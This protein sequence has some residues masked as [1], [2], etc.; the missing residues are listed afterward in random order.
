[1]SVSVETPLPLPLKETR[2]PQLSEKTTRAYM[3]LAPE[4]GYDSRYWVEYDK[5]AK[6]HD[7][8]LV[9]TL[10]SRLDNLIIFA[11]LFSAV[12]TAFIILSLGLLGATPSDNTN[13]LLRLFLSQT[14]RDSSI[15]EA[16]SPPWEPAA[17]GVRTSYLFA[18]SLSCSLLTAAGALVGK[19]WLAYYERTSQTG[20]QNDWAIA[21]QRKS[22]AIEAYH[23]RS[24]L[25]ALSILIQI[26]VL[27]FMIGLIVYIDDLHRGVASVVLAAVVFGSAVYL[28][29]VVV[30]VWDP[31]CPF[32]TPTS[33]ILR[34]L[35]R[36]LLAFCLIFVKSI[37]R[38]AHSVVTR[39]VGNARSGNAP[40][41]GDLEAGAAEKDTGR[42]IFAISQIANI[43]KRGPRTSVAQSDKT[44]TSVS[45][46]ST[47]VDVS[48]MAQSYAKSV[49]WMLETTTNKVA[50]LEAARNI[51]T[52]HDVL[53]TRAIFD[54]RVA[55]V[56]IRYP[57]KTRLM[58]AKLWPQKPAQGSDTSSHHSITS[59]TFRLTGR[60]SAMLKSPAYIRLVTLYRE[61]LNR[62]LLTQNQREAPGVAIEAAVVYG[63][64]ICHALI[65]SP[66]ASDGF[67]KLTKE[68]QDFSNLSWISRIDG[69][70]R[71]ILMCTMNHP[72]FWLYLEDMEESWSTVDAS[73]LPVYIASLTITSLSESALNRER[74]LTRLAYRALSISESIP[75]PRLIGLAARSLSTL[76][77]EGHS[78]IRTLM[79]GL[80]DAYSSDDN[81]ID[82]VLAALHTYSSGPEVTPAY[83]TTY[84][85]LAT[86]FRKFVETLH[87]TL[88]DDFFPRAQRLQ[89]ERHRAAL[90]EHATDVLGAFEAILKDLAE[91][92]GGANHPPET[93]T[94]GT[95]LLTVLPENNHKRLSRGDPQTATLLQ[96][97]I[98]LTLQQGI[99]D[100][101]WGVYNLQPSSA[102]LWE[103]STVVE[104]D[105][106]TLGVVLDLMRRTNEDRTGY[107]DLFQKFPSVASIITKALTS[108]H[109]SVRENSIRLMREKAQSWFHG[110][111]KDVDYQFSQAE[112][113]KSLALHVQLGNTT[114]GRVLSIIRVFE[115]ETMWRIKFLDA[116][117]KVALSVH[118]APPF[119]DS[120][121][122][123]QLALDVW[124]ELT[125]TGAS[126]EMQPVEV[127]ARY[128]D[129]LSEEMVLVITNHIQQLMENFRRADRWVQSQI[130]NVGVSQSLQEYTEAT[131][132]SPRLA[133]N[134]AKRILIRTFQEWKSMVEPRPGVPESRSSL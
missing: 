9:M 6:N 85:A 117:Y 84:A 52:L 45:D 7:Q 34:H 89:R 54:K 109:A 103:T 106:D 59:A 14:L 92:V 131:R 65:S 77:Y 118:R 55:P 114:H 17:V 56:L 21:R 27:L 19:Q 112:F 24:I 20:T 44:D 53:A 94:R 122:I 36:Y 78:D 123:T 43:F 90:R 23:F 102:I 82:H 128:N 16:A 133:R 11:G 119:P 104:I 12:N 49:R 57:S 98:L 113:D 105:S 93:T 51:P 64:A 38:I 97:K 120:V 69:E 134:A 18:A 41:S 121:E 96:Y 25:D 1:M 111:Q 48:A 4:F 71:L 29:T 33:R 107:I 8:A 127:I 79:Q 62:L 22:D 80:W 87:N 99:M 132:H 67:K 125:K 50:L 13:N 63:R 75:T 35:L 88:Q 58:F 60:K 73:V 2:I 46:R 83:N 74:W 126:P 108:S 3:R 124:H 5:V 26:S 66:A 61:S 70:L 37:Q 115:T 72:K 116:F 95:K 110:Q 10:N 76:S 68:L 30:A 47:I 32:Q 86:A 81:I 42:N 100:N 39:V 91:Q 40:S 130:T 15:I 28:Y 31:H 129:W 101:H